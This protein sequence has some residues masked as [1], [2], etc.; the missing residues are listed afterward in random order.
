MIQASVEKNA[1]AAAGAPQS[2]TANKAGKISRKRLMPIAATVSDEPL[3][4]PTH[5]N[6]EGKSEQESGRV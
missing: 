1:F 5:F 6:S 4:L 3:L 2:T